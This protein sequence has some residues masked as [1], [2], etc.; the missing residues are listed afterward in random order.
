MSK[1]D[2]SIWGPSFHFR[3]SL[4]QTSILNEIFPIMH[5][6]HEDWLIQEYRK[7]I[8]IRDET[9]QKEIMD[10]VSKY[11]KHVKDKSKL[12]Q[13]EGLDSSITWQ[14][15]ELKDH[16]LNLPTRFARDPHRLH[17]FS[18]RTLIGSSP[19]F[20]HEMSLIFLISHFEEFLKQLI[21]LVEGNI[22]L[23]SLVRTGIDITSK[24]I[25]K[26]YDIDLPTLVSSSEDWNLI[27]ERFYRRNNL[28]HNGNI[29]DKKYCDL[30]STSS[31]ERFVTDEKYMGITFNLF[32]EFPN[33]IT[34]EF[35]KLIK[36][37]SKGKEKLL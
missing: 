12:Q 13:L 33:K 19:Q 35:E 32:F 26:Q 7:K 6:S 16:D 15:P 25:L 4:K 1:D 8:G 14:I 28:V 10:I 30:T 29:P 17:S 23:Q 34:E 31:R 24:N 3:T 18:L 9:H 2:D 37:D 5:S 22:K 11:D 20:L 21:N 36:N 27:Q